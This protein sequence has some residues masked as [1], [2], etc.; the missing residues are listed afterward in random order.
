MR[1]LS[2]FFLSAR[3]KF[4]EWRVEC[5]NSDRQLSHDFQDCFKIL[6]LHGQKLSQ[7][8]SASGFIIRQ[9][10]LAHGL[11]PITLKK[12]VLGSAQADTFSSESPRNLRLIRL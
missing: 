8:P 11:N 4:M 9:D 1:Q 10:H 6:L 12:H 7:C 2:N 5:P 3:Q